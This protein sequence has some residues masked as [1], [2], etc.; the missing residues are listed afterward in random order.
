MNKANY[1]I[2]VLMIAS[3]Y[4]ASSSRSALSAAYNAGFKT[5]GDWFEEDKNR[6]DLMIWYPT[7]KGEREITISPWIVY[8]APN[9]RCVKGK[10]PL[11]V[12]SHLTPGNRF[13]HR[14]LAAFFARR[15]YIVIVPTHPRDNLDNMDDLY[16]WRQLL[17]RA[18]DID[19]A[20]N[21]ASNYPELKDSL[22]STKIGFI[23]FGSGGATGLLL[24]GAVP[25]CANW[26]TYCQRS[27][28]NDI[29]CQKWAKERIEEMCRALPLDEKVANPRIRAMA[30][31]GPSYGM[32][33]DKY[34]FENYSPETLLVGA[35][36]DKINSIASHTESLARALGKKAFYYEIKDADLGALISRCP[37]ILELEMPDL[38]LS[39][40]PEARQK[41]LQE[42]YSALATF[43]ERYLPSGS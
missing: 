36:G 28:G 19:H 40:P 14:E 25:N 35:T 26:Q 6:M 32:M 43:F 27:G 5:I 3:L 38:C 41:F 18:E 39:V 16:T 21:L 17:R 10:F 22:D 13:S 37:P 29:Y 42:L 15:G 2:A 7:T 12:V 24:G 34:S 4:L 30:I 33:F 23:G 11:L 31:V 9:A 1:I 20:I 8:G